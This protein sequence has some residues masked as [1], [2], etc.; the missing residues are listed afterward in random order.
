MDK[1]IDGYVGTKRKPYLL[2][3]KKISKSHKNRM[4]LVQKESQHLACQQKQSENAYKQFGTGWV[5]GWVG[6]GKRC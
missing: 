3:H 4:T 1:S 5:D 2:R 6:G